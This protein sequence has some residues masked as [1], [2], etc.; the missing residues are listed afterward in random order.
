MEKGSDEEAAQHPNHA[1]RRP[2][3]AKK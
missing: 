3:R 1:T 2:Y